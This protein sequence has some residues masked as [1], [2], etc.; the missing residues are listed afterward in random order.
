MEFVNSGV[1][2]GAEAAMKFMVDLHKFAGTMGATQAGRLTMHPLTTPV[3]EVAKDG[4]TAR[5]LWISPGIETHYI[6]GKPLACSVWESYA[7]DFVKE[8]GVWKWWHVHL[9]RAF[10]VPFDKSWVDIDVN[11]FYKTL[12]R[13]PTVYP[14]DLQPDRP[15]TYH[16]MFSL[17]DTCC[18]TEGMPPAPEPYETWDESMACVEKAK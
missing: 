3:I 8:D 16:K 6:E 5:G 13:S 15:T 2:E 12:G 18:W 4:K 17:N 11:E 9:Y 14:A 1:Y 10:I 7:A